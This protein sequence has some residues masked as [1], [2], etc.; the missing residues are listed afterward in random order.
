MLLAGLLALV[1]R[2]P[3]RRHLAV[4]IIMTII[5]V[6]ALLLMALQPRWSA[7]ARSQNG[8]LL[9]PGA[10]LDHAKALQ[11]TLNAQTFLLATADTATWASSLDDFKVIPDAAYLKRHH[12][13]ID[14][15]HVAGHGLADYDWEALVGINIIHHAG[16]LA[17]GIKHMHWQ[18]NLMAGQRLHIRGVLV[19]S[20]H[21]EGWLYLSD[22]GGVIDSLEIGST[23]DVPFQFSVMP[24]DTGRFFYEMHFNAPAGE[25]LWQEKFEIAVAQPPSLQI[26]VLEA[27]PNFETKYLMRWLAEQNNAVAGRTAISRERFRFAFLNHPKLD[28][29]RLDPSLLKRYD[30]LL[31][32][33]HTLRNLSASERARL[34]EAIEQ[35]GLGVLLMPDEVILNREQQNFSGHEFFLNFKLTAFADLEERLVKPK[36]PGGGDPATTALPAEPFEITYNWNL[37]P[38]I[39]DEHDRIL[40]AAHRR[41][42]GWIALQLVRDSYRWILAGAS[43]QYAAYWSHL[44]TEISRSPS[45]EKWELP[46]TKPI[47][48]DQPLQVRLATEASFPIGT[49]ATENG[50]TD[51]L[52]LRQDAGEPTLWWGTY[53]PRESGWHKIATPNGVSQWFYVYEKHAWQTWQEAG[54]IAATERY[55]RRQENR[56]EPS[57]EFAQ[58]QTAAIPLLIFF[59]IFLGS[60]AYLWLE[61]KL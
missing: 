9:T 36:W 5:A 8:L 41:G 20:Q 40:A 6:M 34:R 49:I 54:K 59:L 25:K 10:P 19:P 48:V 26:L 24:R 17:A 18:R 2:R 58:T 38:L 35:N 61:R 15:L 32:A 46:K 31:I 55:A 45:E 11:A 51:S 30:L 33:G 12:A 60:C 27:A 1:Y 7:R 44:L 39:K 14:T 29:M 52:Y 50:T 22:P 43:A 4:R 28:L 56:E 57:E 21:E 53:W 47:I 37:K 3:Q 42:K 16:P 13:G 23:Q